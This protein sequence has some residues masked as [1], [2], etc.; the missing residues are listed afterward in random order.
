[1]DASALKQLDKFYDKLRNERQL[2]PH[3]LDNYQRDL[4]HLIAFCMASSLE[5]W[6]A[7]DEQHIRMHVSQRHRKGI[8]GKSLQR[9]LS[10]IRT[11]FDY[12]IQ[13]GKLTFNPAKGVKAPK[14]SRKL[15]PT[16]DVDRVGQLLTIEGDDDLAIRDRA[17]LE[18]FY[19][20][21]LRL[22]ELTGLNV[23]SLTSETEI[24]VLGK[25]NK[26]RQLPVGRKAAEA[27]NKWLVIRNHFAA[28]DEPALFVSQRGNR[29]SGRSVQQRLRHWVVK[30]GLD[31]HVHPH[32]LR[33]SFATH[34]LAGGCDLRAVQEMLGHAD[35]AT[36]QMYTHLSGQQLKD[37]Y[38]S[39]HP[40]ATSDR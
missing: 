21:G 5:N 20:S 37:V 1:M 11:F 2:S 18:L 34:L 4:N 28:Q 31:T 7:L 39:A 36:T 33:H 16:L 9:S 22:S 38:F 32:M 40:R 30:Q 15:P 10:A 17:I 3:T 24:R 12:L 35:V 13:E 29:L 14:V 26:E 23:D 27:L 19:S 25:G 6:P 8:S